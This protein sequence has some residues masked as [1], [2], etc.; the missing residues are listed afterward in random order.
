M[1]MYPRGFP[2]GRRRK[3]KRQAER[4]VCEALAGNDR[5]GFVYYQW[6]WGYE[7]IE[8][9]FA[10]WIEDLRR[11]ALQ[12]KDALYG[13]NEG[14][15]RPKA[16]DGVRAIE[17]APLDEAWP[18]PPRTSATTSRN[19]RARPA[20]LSSSGSRSFPTW[21]PAEAIDLLAQCRGCCGCWGTA[22]FS[23]GPE[24]LSR[25]SGAPDVSPLV[26]GL[27][28]EKNCGLSASR[29]GRSRDPPIR[30]L[31]SPGRPSNVGK[32]LGSELLRPLASLKVAPNPPASRT[33]TAVWSAP[34]A[35]PTAR[36]RAEDS[37]QI[38]PLP[39]SRIPKHKREER[40]NDQRK[41]KIPTGKH[42]GH[43]VHYDCASGCPVRARRGGHRSHS[44]SDRRTQARL[45]DGSRRRRCPAGGIPTQ[46]QPG[47]RQRDP[48][49]CR[50]PRAGGTGH[51]R[52]LPDRRCDP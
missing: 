35:G 29:I 3:P 22:N 20:A 51:P 42:P 2:S 18:A 16:G 48:S 23:A 17:T 4:R 43:E 28:E 37:P 41:R 10:V 26:C 49:A 36:P 7:R 50:R 32:P 47:S 1:K 6:P 21:K 19:A 8:L 52:H 5:Q 12:V 38:H 34:N 44:A 30:R 31:S 39:L 45:H 24:G 25:G 33:T 27:S 9:D 40:N 11:T 15:W 13:L 14:E 46:H